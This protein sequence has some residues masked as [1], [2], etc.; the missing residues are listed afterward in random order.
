MLFRS[1]LNGESATRSVAHCARGKRISNKQLVGNA[2]SLILNYGKTID[3]FFK[4]RESMIIKRSMSIHAP[5]RC[6]FALENPEARS[7]PSWV[8]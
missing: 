1:P 4:F 6:S 2:N 7:L 3:F 5:L 8:D